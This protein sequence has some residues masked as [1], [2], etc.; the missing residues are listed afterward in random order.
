[1]LQETLRAE[2]H[3]FNGSIGMVRDVILEVVVVYIKDPPLALL[4]NFDD[5]NQETPYLVKDPERG[6]SLAPSFL[7]RLHMP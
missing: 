5:Y 1:M 3:L 6:R 4:I 7:L 2:H